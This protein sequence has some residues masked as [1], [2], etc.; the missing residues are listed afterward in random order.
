MKIVRVIG[1]LGNQMFQYA[2]YRE[3]IKRG[4]EAKLDISSFDYYKLHNG[5]E[6]DKIFDVDY[7][8]ADYKEIEGIVSCGSGIFPKI[9]R[10]FFS[11]DVYVER[12]VSYK[13]E[14]FITDRYIYYDGYWQSEKYFQSIDKEIREIFKFKVPLQEENLKIAEQMQAESSVSIHIRRGDY[15][16]N[17]S[18]AKLHGGVCDLEY[19][20]RA[21]NLIKSRISNPSFYIF[22]DDKDWVKENIRIEGKLTY[23]NWNFGED[24][25][26]DMQLMSLCKHNIIANSSFSWWGAWLNPNP[27]KIVIAPSKWFNKRKDRDV[28]PETWLR[29]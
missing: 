1:G 23:V 11:R 16:T 15:V 20:K 25:Y 14:V 28:V 24:S 4:Q 26:K 17:P 8:K 7:I 3:L 2:F 13:P 12:E 27:D 29:I 21:I 18:S 22:S 10:R 9:K 5:F 19:Y 6:L